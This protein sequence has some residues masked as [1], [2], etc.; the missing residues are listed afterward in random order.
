MFP[1]STTGA[2]S[3]QWVHTLPQRTTLGLGLGRDLRVGGSLLLSG[4]IALPQH[5][6][7]WL[8]DSHT[9]TVYS[10]YIEVLRILP[11]PPFLLHPLTAEGRQDTSGAGLALGLDQHRCLMPFSTQHPALHGLCSQMRTDHFNNQ[12]SFGV[13]I[14]R[15]FIFKAIK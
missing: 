10:P 13:K 11:P 1:Y 4:E 5:A 9:I 12:S 14:C 6:D 7:L 2:P 3:S 8:V 15:P